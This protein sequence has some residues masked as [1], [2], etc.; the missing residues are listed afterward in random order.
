MGSIGKRH[1]K[2]LEE[3]GEEV[4]GVDKPVKYEISKEID[5]ET[6]STVWI[7]TPTEFHHQYAMEAIKKGVRVFIEKPITS[8]ME[9][10][11]DIKEAGSKKNVWVACN[12]RFHPAIQTLKDSL[13]EVGRVLYSR[14]HFSHY[15]PYQ[16][17]NWQEYMKNT[18][19]VMD[20]G[21]HY[22]DLA[23]WLFGKVEY[24]SFREINKERVEFKGVD[25]IAT[26][27]LYHKENDVF[28]FIHLDYLRRDKA[29]GI[30]IV[31]TEG[32]IEL[33]SNWKN[34]HTTVQFLRK[35]IEYGFFEGVNIDS[36]E[37]YRN[38]IKYLLENPQVTNI[39][40]TIEVMRICG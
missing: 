28:S 10:A 34:E 8:N 39:D 35:N 22:V 38:Q 18:H 4:I 7:C 20:A 2:L 3:L 5:C 11:L 40:D 19:I 1:F 31:G 30:E 12:M 14:M 9:Q 33:K 21:W 23:I 6:Y 17:E 15:L 36:D 32:T 24:S 29:W 25:D 27:K 26:I 13:P 16:R 37:M